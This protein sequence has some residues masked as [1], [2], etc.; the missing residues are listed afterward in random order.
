MQDNVLEHEKQQQNFAEAIRLN[1]EYAMAYYNRGVAWG[2]LSEDE[3][4][5][6]DF[7]KAQEL[8]FVPPE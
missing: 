4:A 1:P 2:E 7:A 6:A 5:E 3:K 8:G